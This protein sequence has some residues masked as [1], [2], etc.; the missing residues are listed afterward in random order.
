VG[1]RDVGL[2]LVQQGYAWH[3]KHFAKEQTD[4]ERFDYERA[5]SEARSAR[6]GLWQDLNPEPP[7]EFRARKRTR[8]AKK[9]NIQRTNGSAD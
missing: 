8:S 3:F 5:E 7:W 2:D 1:S 9:Q 6:L 4:I